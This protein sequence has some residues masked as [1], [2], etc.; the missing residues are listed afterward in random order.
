MAAVVEG[1]TL[2]AWAKDSWLSLLVMYRANL[3]AASGTSVE[4]GTTRFMAATF[5]LPVSPVI[6]GALSVAAAISGALLA[7]LSR[8]SAP[9]DN[10]AISP[11]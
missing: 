6:W 11:A 9:E 8:A 3:T 7:I 10:R 1:S 5:F 2:A 4:R